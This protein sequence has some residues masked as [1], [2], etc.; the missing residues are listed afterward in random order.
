MKSS[1]V[2]SGELHSDDEWES[3][4]DRF[5]LLYKI[6]GKPLPEV[7][8]IFAEKYGFHAT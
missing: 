4:R 6:Q 7:R 1:Q 5:I 8:R 2:K 3:I